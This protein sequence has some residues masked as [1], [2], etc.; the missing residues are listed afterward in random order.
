MLL[1]DCELAPSMDEC[2]GPVC[3]TSL[4]EEISTSHLFASC[5]LPKTLEVKQETP[6]ELVHHPHFSLMTTPLRVVTGGTT[7]Q[8]QNK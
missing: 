3:L 2:S 4:T 7:S 5:L 8:H 1:Y 6:Q